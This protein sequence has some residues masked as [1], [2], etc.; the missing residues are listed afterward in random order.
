MTCIDLKT[1]LRKFFEEQK[2]CDATFVCKDSDGK[3]TSIG[4]HK[5]ILALV[6]DVFETMFFGESASRGL[7]GET[8]EIEVADISA[9]GLKLFFG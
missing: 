9:N 4:A 1:S 3:C 5:L 2:Y 7:F 6:S 8:K